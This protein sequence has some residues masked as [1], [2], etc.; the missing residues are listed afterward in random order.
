[1]SEVERFKKINQTLNKCIDRQKTEIKQLKAENDDYLELAEALYETLG[2]AC[3]NSGEDY[4][5]YFTLA[6]LRKLKKILG[7]G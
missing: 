6:G 2:A 5:G 1:M 3:D 7:K 4:F